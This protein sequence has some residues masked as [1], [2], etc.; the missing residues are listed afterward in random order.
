MDDEITLV[1][2]SN[3]STDISRKPTSSSK[4]PTLS[5]SRWK[6]FTEDIKPVLVEAVS[7]ADINIGMCHQD[8]FTFTGKCK[9]TKRLFVLDITDQSGDDSHILQGITSALPSLVKLRELHIRDVYLG[10]GGKDIIQNI[11]CNNFRMLCLYN[12]HMSESGASL[13]SCLSHLPLLSY[14]VLFNSGLSPA[15]IRQVVQCLPLSC[16]NIVYLDIFG[17]TFATL[18]LQD[19]SRLSAL[20]G[21]ALAT[22]ADDLAQTNKPLPSSI[23]MLYL[24]GMVT[25]S[26][27]LQEFISIIRCC[28]KMM[29][30]VMNQRHLDS[31]SVGMVRQE[32]ELRGGQLVDSDIDSQAWEDYVTEA[33]KLREECFNKE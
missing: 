28:P 32:I 16:P 20:R 30:L 13:L 2:H 31:E 8:V 33:N 27:K 3:H 23:E 29:Y 10:E 7:L 18:E 14:L 24:R 25:I 4:K 21:L 17:I 26:Q 5:S 19:I 22:S 11:Q 15:E 1:I 6:Q 9:N 12:S